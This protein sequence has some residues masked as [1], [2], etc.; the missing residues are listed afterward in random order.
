[1]EPDPYAVWLHK[2][3]HNL[4]GGEGVVSK[5]D[6]SLRSIQL[7][8][9]KPRGGRVWETAF[10]ILDPYAEILMGQSDCRMRVTSRI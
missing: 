2:I 10:T 5:A 3:S 4:G 6:R 8:Q 9:D 1:M 7:F